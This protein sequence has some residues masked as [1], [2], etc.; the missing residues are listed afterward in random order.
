M[1]ATP[2]LF[3]LLLALAAAAWA[4]AAPTFRAA[5]RVLSSGGRARRFLLY[6]PSDLRA[7]RT[8][9]LVL[10]FHGGGGTAEGMEKLTRFDALAE[11]ETFFVAYPEAVGRHWNDGREVE[12][13]ESHREKVDDVAFVEAVIGAI[14]G[15]HPIDPARVYATGFS[16]GAIFVQDL[17]RRLS[18]RIAAIAS[19]AGGVPE[20]L[21]RGFQ[22]KQPVSVL[23]LHGTADPLVPFAGGAVTSGH[24]EVLGA[25]ETA[26]LWASVDGCPPDP[27]KSAPAAHEGGCRRTRERWTGGRDRTEV[28]LDAL[29]GG[30]HTW[31]GGAQ[32]APRILIGRVCP[33]P[34]ATLAIWEFFREH[35]RASSDS[36]APR[37]RP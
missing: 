22:P 34:D 28:V 8:Y 24:G 2:R 31:P 20:P 1:R 12:S 3:A 25:E 21:R 10:V 5:E 7:G 26:R 16:N 37:R 29:E 19:V 32:Y 27:E 4:H 11:R 9:P 6:A 35:P 13:F 18:P 36:A 33:E 14:A 30:G 23:L 17:A 15:E